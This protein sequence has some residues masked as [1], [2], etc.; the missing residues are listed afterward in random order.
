MTVSIRPANPDD[1][2]AMTEL[3]VGDARIRAGREP[4]LW[5]LKADPAGA[6]GAALRAAM[7][8]EAPP[9]RQQWL[10]A[11]NDGSVVGV[12]HSILL[13]VPPIYAGRFGPPGLIMEDSAV[14]DNAPEDTPQA[15][16]EAAERDL[17]EAG[18]EVLLASSVPGGDW[19]RVHE[20]A[21]YAPLT[22]YLARSSLRESEAPEGVRRAT[23]ADIPGIV[24]RSAEHR[25]ILHGLEDFWETHPDADA[26]FGAWMKKSLTLADRDMF[27]AARGVEVDG[28]LVTQ[29]ATPLHFPYAHDIATTGFVDDF[30]HVALSD[31]GAD[32]GIASAADG[33]FVRGETA[34]NARGNA[35][36]LIVCP[37][38]WQSKRAMLERLGHGVVL[39]WRIR[40]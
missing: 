29:P 36:M 30:Y 15:L 21:G 12:V 28:Y 13:P 20:T 5:K 22:L 11:E 40:R 27:V 38:A 33:L 34:L 25:D 31:P 16:L 4:V 9:F 10:L 8:A 35:A 26:R 17:H 23:E 32:P 37:A 24:A 1:I 2:E 14:S 19:E 18:A 6:V 3:M 7:E 39:V